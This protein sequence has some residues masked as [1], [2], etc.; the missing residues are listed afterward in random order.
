MVAD[1]MKM[2]E[3]AKK[4]SYSKITKLILGWNPE[5]DHHLRTEGKR[6]VNEENNNNNNN[7]EKHDQTTGEGQLG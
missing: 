3:I 7:S 1:S 4:K 5:K 6:R 2:H